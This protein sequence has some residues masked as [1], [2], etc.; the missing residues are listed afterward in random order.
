MAGPY[1]V[2]ASAGS[3]GQIHLA[4]GQRLSMRL[5]RNEEPDRKAAVTR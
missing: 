5:W 1:V 3:L 4:S 2:T